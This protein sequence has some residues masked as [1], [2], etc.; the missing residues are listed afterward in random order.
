VDLVR[1]RIGTQQDLWRR[2]ADAVHYIDGTEAE[3]NTLSLDD[4]DFLASLWSERAN[5]DPQIEVF[6][7]RMRN[8][9]QDAAREVIAYVQEHHRL[10]HRIIRTR[11]STVVRVGLK[12]SRRRLLEHRYEPSVPE[13][14]LSR[15]IDDL[16]HTEGLT[17]IQ[18]SLIL[19]YRRLVLLDPELALQL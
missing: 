10:D 18:E 7:G 11:R 16:G 12:W 9:E 8:G 1:Q 19:I 17:R 4:L 5:D 2:L 15:L 3:G 14:N 6:V 13:L